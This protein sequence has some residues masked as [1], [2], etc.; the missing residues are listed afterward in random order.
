MNDCAVP[1]QV[2]S[3]IPDY[4]RNAHGNL[5]GQMRAL[6]ATRGVDTGGADTSKGA[7]V[8][9]ASTTAAPTVAAGVAS[10]AGAMP[11]LQKNACVACHALDSK[12]VGPSLRDVAARYKGRADAAAYLAGRIK[13]G[14]QGTWGS[15][16]MPPQTISDSDATR[17][18]RWLAE[19]AA[20]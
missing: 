12:L 5:A 1:L 8:A 16:P 11:L 6:G 19:G 18:A 7:P 20:P 4:A 3:R 15:T 9:T 2:T 14:G 13:S 10:S 17:V